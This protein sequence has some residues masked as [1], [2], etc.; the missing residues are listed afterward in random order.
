MILANVMLDISIHDTYFVVG[1]FHFVLSLGAVIGIFASFSI[2]VSHLFSSI[3]I[4]SSTILMI[5]TFFV[6]GVL[7]MKQVAILDAHGSL[8]SIPCPQLRS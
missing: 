6:L 8:D 5:G 7:L 4:S 1:H 3:Q 2:Q